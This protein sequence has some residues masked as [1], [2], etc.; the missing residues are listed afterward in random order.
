MAFYDGM[1]EWAD[2]G[3]AVDVVYLDYSKAF[4]TVSCN[5]LPRKLRK[6]GLGEWRVRWIKN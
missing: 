5:I 1:T 3:R 6:C 2:E 4:D